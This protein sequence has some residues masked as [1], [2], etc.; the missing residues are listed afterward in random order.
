MI[1]AAL[2]AYPAGRG[3]APRGTA[4]RDAAARARASAGRGRRRP[5]WTGSRHEGHDHRTPAGAGGGYHAFAWRRSCATRWRRARVDVLMTRSTD[6]LIALRDRGRIANEADATLFLSIH[7]NAANPRWRNPRTARGFET[8]FLSDAK[9]EDD[10]YVA[11]MEN[12]ADRFLG[13]DAVEPGNPLALV[14][15][16]MLQNAHLRESSELAATVQAGLK[17]MHPS[18]NDRGVKQAGFAVLIAAHMPSVLVEIG[19]GSNPS[20][21]TWLDSVDRAAGTRRRDRAI[22]H[23][24]PRRIRASRRGDRR[25]MTRALPTSRLAVELAGLSLQNPL[26]LAS[27]TAGYGRELDGVHGHRCARR[28]GDQGRQHGTAPRRRRSASRR[29]PVRACSTPSGWRTPAS[30]PYEASTC[31]GSHSA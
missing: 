11:E 27:G 10:R 21:A 12:D 31:R 8:Y 3:H 15:G 28:T 2:L 22:H 18:G 1:L 23:Q 19:F 5:R 7:V 14:L 25:K 24:V 6:T 16:D 20:E 30:S 29:V 13:D 17:P 9:T 26:F 4:P